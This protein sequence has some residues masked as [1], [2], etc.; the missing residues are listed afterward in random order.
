MMDNIMHDHI[1]QQSKLEQRHKRVNK[2]T[3]FEIKKIEI[4]NKI[5]RLY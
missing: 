2:S 4:E 1:Q 5:S 3:R